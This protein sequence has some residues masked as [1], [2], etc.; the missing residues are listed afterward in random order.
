VRQQ[1]SKAD[2]QEINVSN[3]TPVPMIWWL[4][5]SDNLHTIGCAGSVLVYY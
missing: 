3:L 2:Y 4:C 5:Q 1:N